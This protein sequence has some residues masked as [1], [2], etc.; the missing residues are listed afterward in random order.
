M[1]LEFFISLKDCGWPLFISYLQQDTFHFTTTTEGTKK[2]LLMI[3]WLAS[4]VENEALYSLCGGRQLIYSD[5]IGLDKL[6]QLLNSSESYPGDWLI[7]LV[8]FEP[9]HLI[10]RR[11]S[12]RPYRGAKRVCQWRLT[13]SVLPVFFIIKKAF[14]W[15]ICWMAMCHILFSLCSDIWL[16]AY[17]CQHVQWYSALYHQFIDAR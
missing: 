12:G 4:A 8:A 6:E 1:V 11:T 14:S 15:P 3:T 13:Y 9:R 7:T 16:K 2:A 17:G 10:H 5:E